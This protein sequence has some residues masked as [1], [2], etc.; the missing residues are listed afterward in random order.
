MIRRMA[1]ITSLAAFFSVGLNA[2]TIA[3]KVTNT[4]GNTAI[5]G[6]KVMLLK[7]GQT[8]VDSG[9]TNATGSISFTVK[10]DSAR[11]SAMASKAGFV[12]ESR[13]PNNVRVNRDTTYNYSITLRTIPVVV[14]DSG[15]VSGT[16]INGTNNTPISGAKVVFSMVYGSTRIDSVTTGAD[17]KFTKKMQAPQSYRVTVSKDGFSTQSQT[18]GSIVPDSTVTLTFKLTPPGVGIGKIVGKVTLDSARG[19]PIA[20]ATII[21][22]RDTSTT[23]Q[24]WVAIDTVTT[25]TDGTYKF[26]NLENATQA[27]P[28]QIIASKED[29][30][31][32]NG[33]GTVTVNQFVGDSAVAN[34]IMTPVLYAELRIKVMKLAD[35]TA[36]SGASV[37][38]STG[39]N[40]T[41]VTGTTGANGWVSFPKLDEGNYNVSVSATGFEIAAR[42]NISARENRIDSV[43][44]YLRAVTAAAQGVKGVV[45]DSSSGTKL[46]GV[47]VR[48]TTGGQGIQLLDTTDANGA[49]S[50][51]G[52]PAQIS[53]VTL[54]VNQSGYFNYTTQVTLQDSTVADVTIKLRKVPVSVLNANS[55]AQGKLSI[56]MVNHGIQISV[57][58]QAKHTS[59]SILDMSG[60]IVSKRIFNGTDGHIMIPSTGKFI[61]KATADNQHITQIISNK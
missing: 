39:F 37:V 12:Y 20:G 22:R 4:T 35:S 2:A 51:S 53:S 3:V 10:A 29:F 32:R 40:Q 21:L 16:V 9:L 58:S 8:A 7:D 52:I 50:F 15:I 25:T 26:V 54:S 14:V 18:T 19:T 34:F 17:G 57:P 33:N 43:Y 1:L 61:V 44:I 5:E 31:I 41:R 59:V 13:Q 45:T 42:T 38:A 46:T 6:A 11:Y 49:F 30:T 56:K 28:Y 24:N 48:M 60:R 23:A 47:V 27:T 55:N 36:V